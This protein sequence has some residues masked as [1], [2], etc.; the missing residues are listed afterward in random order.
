MYLAEGIR[1]ELI[2]HLLHR[3]PN[4]QA[5]SPSSSQA[6]SWRMDG[7]IRRCGG[8]SRVTLQLVWVP[9]GTFRW[10]ESFDSTSPAPRG[11]EEQVAEA[12]L[13]ALV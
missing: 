6:A 4:L 3:A 12:A 13:Q 11:F 5:L 9:D 7:C 10:S 1:Q 2:Q 8:T